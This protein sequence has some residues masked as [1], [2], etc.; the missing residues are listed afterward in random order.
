ML[1]CFLMQ[2][3]FFPAFIVLFALSPSIRAEIPTLSF[4]EVRPGMKGSGRTVFQG[5]EVETF[6]VEIMGR[7]ENVGPDQN[8]IL[9]R[10]SGGPLADTGVLAGMSG[11]PVFIDGKLIGAIAYSW[12]FATEPVVG[13]TPIEE[14]LAIAARS[15]GAP[16]P[17]RTGVGVGPTDL[18]RLSDPEGLATFFARDLRRR[19]PVP[20]GVLPLSIPLTVSGLGPLGFARVVPEL[21]RAGFL[22]LQGGGAGRAADPSPELKPGSAMGLKLARGDLEFTATGTVTW[23]DGERLL[24]F[25]HPLFGL[26]AVDLPLSGARVELLLPSLQQSVRLATP[27]SEVGAIREDRLTGVY[28]RLNAK[29]RMLPVRVQL[30]GESGR[31]HSYS[32]DI[33]DDPLL[34][35]ILLYAS[36]NGI[37]A[38][39]ER[40]FGSATLRLRKGSVIKM[41]GE[42]DIL[43]DNLFAGPTAFDYS[44]GIAA[45]ILYLLMNNDWQPPQIAGV[46]ILIE[47]QET[48][49]TGRIQRVTLDRYRARAGETVQATVVV[50]PFRGPQQVLTREVTIPPET[51]PGRLALH[52]GGAL[53]VSRAESTAEPLLPRDLSQLVW[54]INNLRRNDRIYIVAY[55]E[56]SGVFLGGARLPNLPPSVTS[57][58]TRP[59]NRGNF[60][61]VSRRGVLEEEIPTEYAV[62]G[63]A[64][65]ELEV[66]AP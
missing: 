41:I 55:R 4:E 43:L 63:V 52:V 11:S 25:G 16:R 33:A 27:L 14:M 19:L 53:A 24:A 45:Y 21:S 36:L 44:T 46:N 62:E 28:G 65:I 3:P 48:P 49:Q 7:L 34:S 31:Q 23:V 51:P 30:A 20:A 37:L 66:E 40:V 56:D 17:A 35:P 29:P 47:Y 61:A 60:H 5:T 8:L 13:I 12:P 57:V 39:R 42:E 2:R 50:N 26:G 9:G 15:D 58:L 6:E 64:R 10:C 22:P 1:D 38:S 18:R 54:L 59:R 32:F